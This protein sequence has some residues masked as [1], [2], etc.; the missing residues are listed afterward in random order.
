[1]TPL[2]G[3]VYNKFGTVLE[4]SLG[5]FLLFALIYWEKKYEAG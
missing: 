1:M 3:S 5:V 4:L 2:N